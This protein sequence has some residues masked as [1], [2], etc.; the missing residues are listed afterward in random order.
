MFGT[1]TTASSTGSS[2]GF[3][4][5]S[6]ATSTSTSSSGGGFVFGASTTKTSTTTSSASGFTFGTS[7][8][9]TAA[10]TTSKGFSFGV[11]STQTT[12]DKSVFSF[13]TPSTKPEVTSAS[14]TQT[15]SSGSGFPFGTS[16]SKA[17]GTSESSGFNFG[18][19]E[20]TS[21]SFGCQPSVKEKT[22]TVSAA[23]DSQDPESK[24]GLSKA[25]ISFGSAGSAGF[26]SGHKTFDFE[27]NSS[28]QKPD[29]TTTETTSLSKSVET[30]KPQGMQEETKLSGF[31]FSKEPVFGAD[32]GSKS[33]FQFKLDSSATTSA[34]SKDKSPF[35]FTFSPAKSKTTVP[36]SP[37]VDRDGM[38][39]NKDGEDDHIY[40]EPVI[41]LPEKVEVVTGEEDE[42]VLFEHRAKLFRF[43]NKE[44]KERG[45]GDIKILENNRTKKIRVLMRRE[46]ILKIC[47]NHYITPELDLKPMPNSDGKALT[48][49]ALD[50]SD[51]EAKFEQFSVRF[52]TP[53]IA[54][55]FKE[56][57]ESAK[58]RLS[59][60]TLT[61]RTPSSPA[62][63][64]TSPRLPNTLQ[65]LL[66]EDDDV[67][68]VMEEKATPAQVEKAREFLLPDH[69]YLYENAP[70][71][72]GCI[73]CE[74]YKEGTKISLKTKTPSPK[75][76]QGMPSDQFYF[77]IRHTHVQANDKNC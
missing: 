58:Q 48:W 49:Y 15:G 18:G 44:W 13:G 39:V 14:S 40:F 76:K 59:G 77:P 50:S 61:D 1:T 52:K 34:D 33:G 54:S 45:L 26:S 12:S 6:P 5:G 56:A 35:K 66:S 46:Q 28:E 20:S 55:K 2:G 4:F 63:S 16:A 9:T 41:T 25:A 57:F 22:E 51:D 31:Q 38:Y 64:M 53:E 73:G 29:S 69:F 47:C 65:T 8:K 36:G 3:V 11:P 71:C 62:S 42:K 72:P 67:V 19:I 43:K 30:T 7:G 23:V 17:I 74:D 10:D 60:Q 27:S 70:P 32:S 68:L 37:E 75:K 21:F 24:S